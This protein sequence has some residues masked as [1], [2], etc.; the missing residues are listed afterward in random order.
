MFGKK[1]GIITMHRVE[2]YG[3]LLQAYALQQCLTKLGV[4]SEIIDYKYPNEAHYFNGVKSKIRRLVSSLFDVF[5]GFPKLQRRKKFRKFIERYLILSSSMY[6]T[7]E[8]IEENP[9]YYDFYLTGSDQVWNPK[10]VSTD[11]TFMFSFVKGEIV[12][13]SYASSFATEIIPKEYLDD[14]STYLSRYK[15]ISVRES[16]GVEI[17]RKIT[18]M[19]AFLACDPTLLLTN[20]DWSKLALRSK[21]NVG[22]PYILIYILTY[23][24]NPY[25]EVDELIDFVQEKMG[26]QIIILNGRKEDYY[27]KNTR[28]IKNAGPE[29]FIKLFKCASFVITTSFHGT[30]FAQIFKVPFYS[31][32][33]N[34]SQSDSRIHDLLKNADLESRLLVCGCWENLI[35][36]LDIC[37]SDKLELLIKKSHSY[38][39]SIFFS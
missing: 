21:L 16:S 10:Y 14:Y 33:K 27:R 19:N 8:E 15:L 20:N 32:I 5:L 9:P 1:T 18:G 4:N 35:W 28:V 2:N 12:C 3:S 7:K 25:P 36:E 24:F 34:S 26:M 11:P 39:S 23:S 13:A 6:H 30:V 17:V 22:G 29:D 31:I 37:W 38:L